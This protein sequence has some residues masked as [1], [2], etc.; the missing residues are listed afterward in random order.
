M[1][2]RIS[3]HNSRHRPK[4]WPFGSAAITVRDKKGKIVSTLDKD[5]FTLIDQ[6]APQTISY[7]SSERDLPLTLG[8]L[9]TRASASAT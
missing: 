5:N 8:A 9:V 4:R 7:F 2:R 6:N 1:F 3:R